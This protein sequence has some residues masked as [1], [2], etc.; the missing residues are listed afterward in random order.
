[1]PL[2]VAPP[3]P[4]T[5]PV[6]ALCSCRVRRQPPY[7]VL[8]L[9]APSLRQ[10][11]VSVF[12]LPPCPYVLVHV[13]PATP[14]GFKDRRF[15]SLLGNKDVGQK[16]GAPQPAPSRELPLMSGEETTDPVL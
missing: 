2:V 6:Y 3:R 4:M 1:M 5:N 13:L 14:V 10:S 9:T 8:C 7:Q 16:D 12:V 11:P 15:V